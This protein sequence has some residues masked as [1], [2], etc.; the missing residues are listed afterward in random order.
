[1]NIIKVKYENDLINYKFSDNISDMKNGLHIKYF[2]KK[3][4]FKK[5]GII[6]SIKDNSIL[7]LTNINRKKKWFIYYDTNYIFYKNPGRVS[8]KNKLEY[9]LNNNFLIKK[10]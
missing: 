10:I 5:G 6:N 1:M 2:S 9:L 8:L 3:N 4:L 7:E